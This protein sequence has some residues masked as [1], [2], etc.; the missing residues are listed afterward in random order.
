MTELDPSIAVLA[1]L[2][3]LVVQ[4]ARCATALERLAGTDEETK[5]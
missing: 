1:Q 3:A 5:P 4:V 2:A